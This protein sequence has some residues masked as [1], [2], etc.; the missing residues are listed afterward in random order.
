MSLKVLEAGDGGYF[1]V[2]K[3][4]RAGEFR[5]VSWGPKRGGTN[6]EWEFKVWVDDGAAP[7]AKAKKAVAVEPLPSR[8]RR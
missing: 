3:R 1:D 4:A 7:K 6:G 8:S 5:L 2:L